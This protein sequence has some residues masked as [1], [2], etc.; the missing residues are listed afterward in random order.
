MATGA[1]HVEGAETPTLA[2]LV[3]FNLLN[4]L[5]PSSLSISMSSKMASGLSS[6]S[7]SM[8]TAPSS[9]SPATSSSFHDVAHEAGIVDD[10]NAV[11]HG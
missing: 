2:L 3:T 10:E 5:R 11:S 4:A 8:A 9:A 6:R 7:F 1:A